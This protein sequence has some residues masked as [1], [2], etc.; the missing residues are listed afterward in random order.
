MR[1][2]PTT[3]ERCTMPDKSELLL[4]CAPITEKPGTDRAMR[5]A[6][7]RARHGKKA[8]T[9]AHQQS[10]DAA[11]AKLARDI[12]VDETIAEWFVHENLIP[13]VRSAWKKFVRNPVV[14]AIAVARLVS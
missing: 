4:G 6:I 8:A 1:P 10:F 3:G 9:F 14:I 13:G 11:I 7:N 12:P 2:S 5:V